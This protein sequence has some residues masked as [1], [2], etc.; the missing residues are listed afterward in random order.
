MEVLP[1]RD[2]AVSPGGY[3]QHLKHGAREEQDWTLWVVSQPCS[4]GDLLAHACLAFLPNDWM[5]GGGRSSLGPARG[6]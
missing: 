3:D 6:W 2:S 5:M 1:D 4:Q